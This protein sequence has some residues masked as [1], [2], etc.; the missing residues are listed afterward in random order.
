MDLLL[1]FGAGPNKLPKPWQNLGP[2]DDIRKPLKFQND[3]VAA[4]LAEHVIEHV[5][6][7]QALGFF[8][9]CRRVLKP[10]GLLRISFPDVGRFLNK[11]AGHFTFNLSAFRYADD[12]RM[13][14][15]VD[16]PGRSLERA[17]GALRQMLTG[18]GHQTDWTEHSA[19]G[20]LLVVGFSQVRS[21][22]YSHGELKDVDGHHREVGE[23]ALLES[24]ILEARK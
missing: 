5:P 14:P 23:I 20:A 4:I 12:L 21:R 15:G 6:F 13:R 9:E 3:S 24:T 18:W 1:N 11:S 8:E 16:L 7:L 10:R 17:R 2:S 19:A 22:Q